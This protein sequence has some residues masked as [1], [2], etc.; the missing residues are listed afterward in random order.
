MGYG[1]YY[2]P[3]TTSGLMGIQADATLGK[4]DA[5]VQLV[6]SSPSNPRS[7]FAKDQY[8]NWAGGIGYTIRQ[9][10]R[11]GLSSYRGPYLDRQEPFFHPGEA[12][13]KDLPATAVGAD[14]E[15]AHGHWNLNGE[16]QHFNMT[17]H[18]LPTFREEAAY[19]EA[20]R[21]LHP[22][23]YLAARTGY[24]HTSAHSGGETYEAAVGFRPNARQ[25]IKIDYMLESESK[26]G[27]IDRIT[28]VQLVTMLHPLSLAW[29]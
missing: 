4:W 14:A 24:L 2:A 29:H 11:V 6:N 7:I 17:Y 10:F 13:P 20:K 9:G 26:S 21:V 19:F 5:R 12:E 3:V 25:L 28:G 27:R 1:Y 15:W 18:L 23:W 8:G 16:W 22:R